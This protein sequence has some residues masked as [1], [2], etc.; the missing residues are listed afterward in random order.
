VEASGGKPQQIVPG[1]SGRT[2]AIWA[3]NG[4]DILMWHRARSDVFRVSP[5]RRMTALHLVPPGEEVSGLSTSGD[6]K[7]LFLSRG[8]FG[9]SKDLWRVPMNPKTGAPV[10]AGTALTLPLSDHRECQVSPD[11]HSLAFSMHRTKRHLWLFPLDASTGLASGPP[12]QLTFRGQRN[13]YPALTPDGRTVIYTSQDSD[14]GLL[15]FQNLEEKQEH[16]LTREWA[17][18]NREVLASF[19]PTGAVVFASTLQKAFELYRMPSLGSV[20]LRITTN[21]SEHRDTWPDWSPDGKTIVFQS[22]REGNEDLW[23]V[24]ADGSQRKRLTSDAANESYPAVSPDGLQVAYVTDKPI[25][26][27]VWVRDLALGVDKPLIQHPATDGPGEWSPDGKRF[28]FLSDRDGTVGV[29]VTAAVGGEARR[30]FALPAPLSLPEGQSYGS[31]AVGTRELIVPLESRE[32]SI[33][34]LEG[35]AGRPAN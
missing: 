13:Y 5:D 15:Y 30:V 22:N 16:K 28:Y 23:T 8:S 7:W 17:R 18:D 6:G 35:V 25:N 21:R 29:W 19:S 34:I 32:S 31:F 4:L 26:Q 11:G 20:G 24:Q 14:K 12:R 10:G 33:H 27:D 9:G 2:Y 1:T 3:A